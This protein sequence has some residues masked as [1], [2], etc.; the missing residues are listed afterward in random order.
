[1]KSCRRSQRSNGGIVRSGCGRPRRQRARIGDLIGDPLS[2]CG[3][4]FEGKG[5]GDKERSLVLAEDIFIYAG[6]HLV[7]GHSRA[8]EAVVGDRPGRRATRCRVWGQQVA[9][10]SRRASEEPCSGVDEIRS[11]GVSLVGSCASEDFRNCLGGERTY[12]VCRIR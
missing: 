6:W 3:C 2:C 1:V 8:F 4:R 10:R 12:H 5:I 11:D 7:Q 9:L